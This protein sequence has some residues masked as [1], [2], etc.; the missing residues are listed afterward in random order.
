MYSRHVAARELHPSA[1]QLASANTV[2]KSMSN[3]MLLLEKLPSMLQLPWKLATGSPQRVGSGVPA[4]I[5]DGVVPSSKNQIRIASL[6]HCVA[7]TPPPLL[8]KLLP[9]EVGSESYRTL[10]PE[11]E[12]QSVDCEVPICPSPATEHVDCLESQFER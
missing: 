1:A 10:Q 4:V 2:Q 6:S 7:K 9:K 12:L 11:L 5:S 3:T 8:S